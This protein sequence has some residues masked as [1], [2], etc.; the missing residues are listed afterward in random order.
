MIK[1]TLS[2]VL[3]CAVSMN[4]SAQS[5][6]DGQTFLDYTFSETCVVACCSS[7]G[8]AFADGNIAT[9]YDDETN[10]IL[11]STSFPTS[12]PAPGWFDFYYNNDVFFCATQRD[13]FVGIDLSTYNT[14]SV[15]AYASEPTIVEFYVGAAAASGG[16]YGFAASTY[17]ID[18]LGTSIPLTM[19]L[20]ILPITFTKT[21]TEAEW[22]SWAGKSEIDMFGFVLNDADVTVVIESIQ[23]GSTTVYEDPVCTIPDAILCDDFETYTAGDPVSPGASWWSTWSGAEGGAEDGT[24]SI[25]QAYSGANSMLIS[26]G[27]VVDMLLLLGNQSTGIFDLSWKMY[28]PD[29]KKGYINVQSNEVPG[30]GTPM[31]VLFGLEDYFVPLPSG[32]GSLRTPN[33]DDFNYPVDA[34]FTV[35]ILFDLDNDVFKILIDDML[36]STDV[37]SGDLGAIDFYSINADNR[38][39]IDDVLFKSFESVDIT[40]QVDIKYY[41]YEGAVL[42]PGDMRMGGNFAAL[43]TALPDWTPSDSACAMVNIDADIWELTVN[44]PFEAIGQDQL[45]KFVNGDWGPVGDGEDA[46]TLA[47]GNGFDRSQT[48]PG[49]SSSYLW[50]WESCEACPPLCI[51]PDELVT[52]DITSNSA[53]ISWNEVEGTLGY[54][55]QLRNNLT[56]VV[57]RKKVGPAITSVTLGDAFID[58]GISYSWTVRTIC[59]DGNTP[60]GSIQLFTSPL[61]IG[62]GELDALIYPNPNNGEFFLQLPSGSGSD[63]EITITDMVGKV[64]DRQTIPSQDIATVVPLFLDAEGM[65]QVIVQ[66][67][68]AMYVER[69]ILQK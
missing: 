66:S 5:V 51:T 15:T 58:P 9:A 35:Q 11:E 65:Y 59:E 49:M 34:W 32:Q 53:T 24:V 13:N 29:G 63:F 4:L 1:H 23:L 31:E 16:I 30:S 33:S 61:R 69:V 41:L 14:I 3:A 68:D 57:K 6:T 2:T 42:N 43:G 45:F 26:E 38:Y 17:N 21:F 36:V 20:G 55:F 39:Y 48:V 62:Y 12:D 44:Y 67:N 64:V 18:V 60:W 37:Y 50:C 56:G 10:L 28:I 8:Y 22:A 25:E 19:N 40:Y 52:S 47:C 27:A 54:V 46:S 7:G